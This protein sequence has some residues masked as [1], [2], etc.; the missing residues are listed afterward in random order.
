MTRRGDPG[1]VAAL[2]AVITPGDEATVLASLVGLLTVARAA[3]A[4]VRL[5]CFRE[6]PAPRVD[7]H[8]RVVADVEAEMARI[9]RETTPTLAAS[10][11]VFEGVP[12]ETG[13][14]PEPGPGRA[15]G[16]GTP[17]STHT[18]GTPPS[19]SRVRSGCLAQ[20]FRSSAVASIQLAVLGSTTPPERTA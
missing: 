3:E 11:C 13:G 6:L 18:A 5:A 7:R 1:T 9:E 14:G 8:G 4:D 19:T 20:P 15:P 10:A 16:A 2:L 17:A 12:V